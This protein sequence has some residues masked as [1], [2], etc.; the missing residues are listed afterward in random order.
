LKQKIDK[1]V[2]THEQIPQNSKVYYNQ[3]IPK[4]GN[5]ADKMFPSDNNSLLP[6]QPGNKELPPN[7]D[8]DE[9]EG[10]EEI[11]WTK[12]KDIFKNQITIK[13]L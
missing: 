9:V 1:P 5:F 8:Q 7:V 12:A 13:S 3:E 11:V 6:V 4:K 2:S 10:W